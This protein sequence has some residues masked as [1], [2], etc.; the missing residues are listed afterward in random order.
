MEHLPVDAVVA[1]KTTGKVHEKGG[2]TMTMPTRPLPDD[3]P[4]TW[5]EPGREPS[6][7]KEPGPAPGPQDPE[8]DELRRSDEEAGL[9]RDH[10]PL[11]PG[12]GGSTGAAR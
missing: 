8:D 1:G 12:G 9:V 11:D 10:T 6:V 5:P 4:N 7:P 3:D 2:Q